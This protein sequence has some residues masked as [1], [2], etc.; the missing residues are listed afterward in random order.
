M[1]QQRQYGT[2]PQ[3]ELAT[4]FS[5]GR[6]IVKWEPL[7]DPQKVFLSPLHIKLGLIKQCVTALYKECADFKYLPDLFTKPSAAEVKAGVFVG[8]QIIEFNKLPKMLTWTE[9]TAWNNFVAGVWD[10]R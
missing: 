3:A 10:F 9:K 2:L 7:L 4:E 8:R 5:V 6:N 1:K